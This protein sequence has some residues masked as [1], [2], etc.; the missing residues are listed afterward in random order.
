MPAD[1]LA[2]HTVQQFLHVEVRQY[3]LLAAA[4]I[5]CLSAAVQVMNTEYN[6]MG[7]SV[8]CVFVNYPGQLSLATIS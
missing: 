5:I 3:C 4:L 2:C 7:N 6:G 8:R 1:A